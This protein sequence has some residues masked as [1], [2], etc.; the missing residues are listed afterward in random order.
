VVT[1]EGTISTFAGDG[2][3]GS[4]GDDGPAASAQFVVPVDLS[5]DSSGNLFVADQGNYRIRKIDAGGTVS[6]VAGKGDGDGS[7]M[8]AE[9]F[10]PNTIAIDR[11]GNLFIADTDIHRIRRITPGG[12]MTIVAGNGTPGFSGDGG[13]AAA[14]QLFYPAGITADS[15]GNLFIADTRN[16]RI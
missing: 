9:L 7:P 14:A 12:V 8:S 6:S 10:F 11:V 16:E 13:S 3:A 1:P 2:T 4:G 15:A 5:A